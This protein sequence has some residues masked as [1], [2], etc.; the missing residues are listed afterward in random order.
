MSDGGSYRI[1]LATAADI[2]AMLEFQTPA[3]SDPEAT[4]ERLAHDFAV[5]VPAGETFLVLAEV[6]EGVVGVARA[7][8]V[9]RP[10]SG[11]DRIPTGWYL[12]G[13]KVADGWRR[14]G[15]GRALTKRRLEWLDKRTGVVFYTTVAG[16]RA[17]IALHRSF[18]FEQVAEGVDA[19]AGQPRADRLLFRRQRSA[20]RRPPPPP[21]ILT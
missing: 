17:S 5:R 6:A 14:L 19:P 16:N 10:F 7:S 13:V 18:G 11:P 12:L 1:R 8:R 21:D 15:V 9:E 2:P 3:G 20:H 4:R